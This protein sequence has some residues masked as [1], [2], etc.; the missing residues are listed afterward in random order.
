MFTHAYTYSE[1]NQ[2]RIVELCRI[3]MRLKSSTNYLSTYTFLEDAEPLSK[4][5]QKISIWKDNHLQ[6]FEKK[7][8]ISVLMQ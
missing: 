1:V 2:V 3:H 8:S 6:Y 7:I 5:I 4:P